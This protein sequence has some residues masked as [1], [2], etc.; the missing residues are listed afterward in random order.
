MIAAC[1]PSA[2]WW[3]GVT[4]TS[5]KPTSRSPAVYSVKDNAPAMQPT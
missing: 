5:V 3:V 2:A 4:L 1:M